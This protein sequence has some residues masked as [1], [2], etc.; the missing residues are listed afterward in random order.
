MRV[1]NIGEA[2]LRKRLEEFGQTP[3]SA[4]SLE[5]FQTVD[6]EEECDPPAFRE[7]RLKV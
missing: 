4:L 5:D 7:S 3:T 1:V 6:L 2:V